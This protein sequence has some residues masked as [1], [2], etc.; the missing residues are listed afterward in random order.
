MDNLCNF[1]DIVYD[2]LN[3]KKCSFVVKDAY[4]SVV[5]ALR[6]IILSEIPN[7]AVGFDAYH[8]NANDTVFLH[9]T[10]SLHNEFI[11]HRLSLIPIHMSPEMIDNYDSEYYQF[12]INVHNKS[13]EP[14]L[15]TSEHIV[16]R[17]ANGIELSREEVKKMFP[18]CK[19][20]NDYIIIV[21]LKPNLYDLNNGEKLHVQ[22]RARRGIAKD[23][24][25]WC[26]VSLCSYT[27]MIDEDAAKIAKAAK[28][29]SVSDEKEQ[30]KM[31]KVFETLEKQRYYSKNEYG[32]PNMFKFSIESECALS[33]AYLVSKGLDILIEK[34]RSCVDNMDIVP[35][36]EEQNLYAITIDGEDHTLGNV[37]Q[38][39]IYEQYIRK[40]KLVTF[41]GY[42]M[43]HPL[44]NY[45]VLK[46][47][48]V[49]NTNVKEFITQVVSQGIDYLQHMKIKW[50][51]LVG[52]ASEKSAPKKIVIKKEAATSKEAK[53]PKESK[54]TKETK[55]LKEPK[56]AKELKE[57]KKNKEPKELKETKPK[58]KLV[59]SE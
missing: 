39:F 55:E 5:N 36:N 28:L 54:K 15:V 33:P 30:E 53:K 20:T 7:I 51:N 17:G 14:I 48:F 19:I 4:L 59:I 1:S 10:S 24:A 32:D 40:H 35:I 16:V 6:R 22:F 56:E 50:N 52:V 18:P 44:E 34:L 12:E 13:S 37:L 11:G 58:K 9:N 31:I 46:I 2:P 49:N 8:K 47:R 57:P 43:P 21:K 38:N 41:A 42:N 23:K 29:A 3:D 25:S 45:I 27:F 26:P